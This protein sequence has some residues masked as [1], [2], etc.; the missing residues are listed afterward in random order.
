MADRQKILVIAGMEDGDDLLRRLGGASTISMVL[1][2]RVFVLQASS[3]TVEAISDLPGVVLASA[4]EIPEEALLG[5]SEAEATQ[6]AAWNL[7]IAQ[8][9]KTR[10]GE[11]MEWDAEGFEAP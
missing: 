6:I 3:P 7:R 5:M 1:S 11:G 2:P 4:G 8:K 9:D 10:P